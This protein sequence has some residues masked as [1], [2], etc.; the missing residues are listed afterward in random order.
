MR[1][2]VFYTICFGFV[3][4]VLLRFLVSVDVY[5]TLLFT[6]IAFAV[7]LFFLVSPKHG[8]GGYFNQWGILIS[9]FIFVFCLGV[10]RFNMVDVPAPKVLS[11][12]GEIV[13]EPDIR[14]ENQKL[15]TFCRFSHTSL[16]CS[17]V[18][19][20]NIGNDKRSDASFSATGKSPHR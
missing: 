12:Q 6:A 16:T 13:D 5:M 1:D 3:F 20:A 10:L 19:S 7:F 11:L 17:S 15:T 8:E 14:E 18:S 4:G 2:K 9:I